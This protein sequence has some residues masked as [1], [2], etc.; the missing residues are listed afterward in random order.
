MDLRQLR[1]FVAVA[2]EGHITRAAERLGMHQPPLSAQIKAIEAGL[3][4]QL[5]KRRPRGVELTD[6]GR[7]LLSEA[8]Q[9]LA[10]VERALLRT[11]QTARGEMGRLCVAIAPTAPFHKLVPR[12]IR[13]YRKA[14]PRV[15]LTLEEGL[16]NEVTSGL[17]DQRI[18]VAFVRNASIA[19]EELTTIPLLEEPM[20]LAIAAHHAASKRRPSKRAVPLSLLKDEPFIFIGPP[21]TG[22]HDETIAACRS[23][24]Y[25]PRIGQQPPRITSALGLIAAEL[26]VALVPESLRALK[27]DGVVFRAVSAPRLPKAFLGLTVR[28]D[29]RSE[30]I[31]KFIATV[32]AANT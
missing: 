22:L 23:A 21:G 9:I 2:E 13:N 12:A 1:Y 30:V 5:F 14:F 3:Q 19:S 8:R 25:S 29:A 24:G 20:V 28:K 6:A 26:G 15:A 32:R 10:H 16:S 11:R 7:E 4:V 31:R 27:M 17:I 18:D